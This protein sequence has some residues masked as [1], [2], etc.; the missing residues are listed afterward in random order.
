VTEGDG[1]EKVLISVFKLEGAASVE[2][3]ARSGWLPDRPIMLTL[4]QINIFQMSLRNA[5]LTL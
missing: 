3:L 4:N 1:S 2:E 5:F